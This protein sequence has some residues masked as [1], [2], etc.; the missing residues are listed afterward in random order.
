ML[1]ALEFSLLPSPWEKAKSKSKQGQSTTPPPVPHLSPSVP[2]RVLRSLLLPVFPPPGA[3]ESVPMD[4]AASR[5]SY[6]P[7][8]GGKCEKFLL[9]DSNRVPRVPGT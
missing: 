3:S 9:R 2:C 1:A 8:T 7:R 6:S 4:A 5:W